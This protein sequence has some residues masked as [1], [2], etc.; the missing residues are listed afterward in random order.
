M[1]LAHLAYLAFFQ[2][3]DFQREGNLFL[4]I[5]HHYPNKHARKEFKGLNETS[6]EHRTLL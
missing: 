1:P 4:A 6:N 3:G 2:E 5:Q